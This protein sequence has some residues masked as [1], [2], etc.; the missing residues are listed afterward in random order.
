[1]IVIMNSNIKPF[2][3]RL[4]AE[5]LRLQL[6]QAQLADA[7]GVSKSTQ[8]GYESNAYIPDLEYLARV[9]TSKV[10]YLRDTLRTIQLM[11]ETTVYYN[12]MKAGVLLMLFPF[13]V[14]LACLLSGLINGSGALFF[15][16]IN[17]FFW[18]CQPNY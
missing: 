3:Q 17:C 10:R 16:S 5:R 15:F 14:G 1:M 7:G 18:S 9:G 12:P 2:G 11:L 8:V 13:F 6:S 4:K